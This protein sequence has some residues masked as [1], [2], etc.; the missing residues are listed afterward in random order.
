L[1]TPL[2]AKLIQDKNLQEQCLKFVAM[3]GKCKLIVAERSVFALEGRVL[4]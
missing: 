2:L 1:T 3:R 4:H